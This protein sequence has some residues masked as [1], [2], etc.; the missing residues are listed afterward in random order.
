MMRFREEEGRRKV[1]EWKF[2]GEKLEEVKESQY[3]GFRFRSN[4]G[5]EG[6]VTCGQC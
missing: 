2:R 3:L 5:T 1:T 4:G 6:H